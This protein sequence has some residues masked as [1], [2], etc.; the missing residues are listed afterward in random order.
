MCINALSQ[1]R[2]NVILAVSPNNQKQWMLHWSQ[3]IH[4]SF[5]PL[6]Y[7]LRAV[8]K[9]N[10]DWT[11]VTTGYFSSVLL[12]ISPQCQYLPG[13]C[14]AAIHQAG[15]AWCMLWLNWCFPPNNCRIQTL[16]LRHA[17]NGLFFHVA[18]LTKL[19]DASMTDT[20][21]RDCGKKTFGESKTAGRTFLCASFSEIS[22]PFAFST[23]RRRLSNWTC[24]CERW[25]SLLENI[26]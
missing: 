3:W 19:T 26:F 15:P 7:F 16:S 17:A 13:S 2:T 24:Y 14:W 6:M 8:P 4:I 18:A 5:L 22:P 21:W 23:L 9:Y 20:S 1:T 25:M 12:Q 10:T 11:K